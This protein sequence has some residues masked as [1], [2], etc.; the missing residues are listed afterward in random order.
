MNY[1]AKGWAWA[2]AGAATILLLAWVGVSIYAFLDNL[3]NAERITRIEERVIGVGNGKAVRHPNQS[4]SAQGLGIEGGD[5]HQTPSKA[6]QQPGPHPGGQPTKPKPS[7][8]PS[9]PPAPNP[10]SGR[11]PGPPPQ[12]NA[13]PDAGPPPQAEPAAPIREVV[14]GAK[15][16]AEGVVCSLPVRLCP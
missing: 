2:A 4:K 11:T 14:E 8:A 12:S 13:P 3:S 7:P 1:K 10:P 15:G 6:H 5:A 9:A 16:T